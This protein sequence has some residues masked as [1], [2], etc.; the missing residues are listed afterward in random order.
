LRL[1]VY[2][3]RLIQDRLLARQELNPTVSR[4]VSMNVVN[5]RRMKRRVMR[6]P[7]VFC[8]VSATETRSCLG[9]II[10]LSKHGIRFLSSMAI[11]PGTL[12][13]VFPKHQQGAF[14]FPASLWPRTGSVSYVTRRATGEIEVGMRF[15]VQD[16]DR[17]AA[18]AIGWN[19]SV[20][21]VGPSDLDNSR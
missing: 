14:R 12:L 20:G 2:S 15:S 6:V 19:R 10:S 9:E 17:I 16:V 8:P 3:L 11:A 7:A 4:E 13:Q 5:R 18:K 21:K 1:A